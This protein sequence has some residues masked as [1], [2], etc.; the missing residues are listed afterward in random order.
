MFLFLKFT[1]L[2]NKMRSNFNYSN[3][4]FLTSNNLTSPP[5][6]SFPVKIHFIFLAN[7]G[8]RAETINNFFKLLKRLQSMIFPIPNY[9]DFVI[10]KALTANLVLNSSIPASGGMLT[11]TVSNTGHF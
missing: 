11:G 10:D 1:V 4:E 6:L 5:T 3:S 2:N 8:T 7:L 9:F